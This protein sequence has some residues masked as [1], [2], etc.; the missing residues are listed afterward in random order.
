MPNARNLACLMDGTE[1]RSCLSLLAFHGILHPT[2]L[3][4][5]TTDTCLKNGDIF[6]RKGCI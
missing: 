4:C 3:R 5:D 6:K 2:E 1:M